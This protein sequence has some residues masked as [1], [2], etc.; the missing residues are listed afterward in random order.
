MNKLQLI[1]ASAGSGKTYS[2]TERVLSEVMNGVSPER[3][4][5]VTFTNKAAAELKERIR[6]KLVEQ[7]GEDAARLRQQA[8][9]LA[10]AY[11]GT[12][13]S[14]CA[15]LLREFAF[16]AGLSPAID[17]LPE[18]ESD[19]LFLLAVSH[20]IGKYYSQLS[21]VARR[22]G[23]DGSGIGFQ[24]K[25]DWK[26]D[27][28]TLVD[29]ARTNGL[30]ADDL[31]SMS[32]ASIKGLKCLLGRKSNTVSSSELIKLVEQAIVD[33]GACEDE[34]KTTK[35]AISM[36]RRVRHALQHEYATWADWAGL[37]GISAGTRS[38]ANGCLESVRD[39]ALKV[40]SHPKLQQDIEI[41]VAGVFHCA[42]EALDGFDTYKRINGLMDFVDQESK[43]LEL[44]DVDLVRQR[45]EERIDVVMVDEFQDTSPIQ[46]AL[47]S[48]LSGLVDRSVWVGDQKQAIYGFRGS[49]PK[50]MDEVIVRLDEGQLDVLEDSYRSRPVLVKF[51]NA[52]FEQAFDGLI[53]GER[54]R[55]NAKRVDHEG[56]ENPLAVWQL[57]GKNKGLRIRA[58]A[59]GIARLV[60]YPDNW[61]IEDLDTEELRPIRPGDIAVLCRTNDNCSAVAE[62]LGKY[63][64]AVSVGR[65]SLLSQPESI[66]LLGGMRLLVDKGDTL[67]LA[68]LVQHLPGHASAKSWLSELARGPEQAFANW[69]RDDRIARLLDIRDRVVDATPLELLKMVADILGLR[70]M[71]FGRSDPHQIL[72]NIEAIE[73][74]V[75]EYQDACKVRHEGASLPGLMHW[76][77]LLDEPSLPEGRG[78]QTIQIYSYH[79][80][81]GLEWPVVILFDLDSSARFSPFGLHVV[82]AIEFDPANPLAARW[83][84][85][86]PAPLS[87][88]GTP[89]DDAVEASDE[90]LQ[91]REREIAERRR[92]MY[93][94]M[95]RA[96][97]YLILT[98]PV[99]SRN[100]SLAWLE[101]LLPN[102]ETEISLPEIG[103]KKPGI[104]VAGKTFDCTLAQWKAVDDP[105]LIQVAT[106][107][108]HVP[109]KPA[110]VVT[111]LPYAV[112][113]SSYQAPMG[114]SFTIGDPE[115]IGERITL[116]QDVDMASLGQAIH[117]FIAADRIDRVAQR[118]SSMAKR[119]LVGWGVDH[120]LNADR[121]ME[122][123]YA[124]HSWVKK[125]WPGAMIY[126][127]WPVRMRMGNQVSHGWIDALVDIGDSY[128]IVDHKSFPGSDE[129]SMER[130]EEHVGQLHLYREAVEKAS[131]KRV[132]GL[133]IYFAMQGSI[134]RVDSNV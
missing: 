14:I 27:V 69:K 22:F 112:A 44:L 16:E 102:P 93:V 3:I 99:G 85:Y 73:Q 39:Y 58:L 61:L 47:F 5:A 133:A 9:R 82:P 121:L 107:T 128:V 83:I 68:E 40:Q 60:Q 127:E 90:L 76:L 20:E 34:T 13:N 54:V 56:Q 111:R 89:F 74:L 105:E 49:D 62:A 52:T 12:V 103:D 72:A 75:A 43:V 21:D 116:S 117:H 126:K 36:L 42:A 123:S 95:T 31:M 119:I 8:S 53:P 15:R 80:A 37:A 96:R 30:N 64:I 98:Q 110:E 6:Q 1:S 92:L 79:K 115:K 26:K 51:V 57:E 120:A 101:D 106:Q 81:K 118:R 97:D 29:L 131:G 65:G 114:V 88:N 28:Q 132:T 35:N 104:G 17:I 23:R 48:K 18:G 7:K 24:Q 113:P 129:K 41:L 91:A 45:L 59:E 109:S 87:G 4:M 50:L 32:A 63:G 66:A 122:I 11:V 25:P 108:W 94:G 2:L 124:F 67:A 100:T 78:E 46:L 125:T 70:D 55:L 19:R 71:A 130:V 38:G 10:D 77:S 84:R 86:W 33:I 134:V